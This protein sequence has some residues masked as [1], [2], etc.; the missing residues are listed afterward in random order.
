[1]LGNQEAHDVIRLSKKAQT[2]ENKWLIKSDQMFKKTADYIA[3]LVEIGIELDPNRIDFE[4]FYVDQSFDVMFEAFKTAQRMPQIPDKSRLAYPKGAMPRS[5]GELM[6]LWD[7]WRTKKVIPAR[8]KAIAAKVKKKYI[9]KVQKVTSK[10]NQ[11]ILNGEVVEKKEIIDDLMEVSKAD[12]ARS[13]TIVAT[14]TTRYWNK[15]RKD[16]YDQSPDV[17]HYLYLAVRD[18]ATTKWCRTRTGLV[19][20]KGDPILLRE[21]PPIHW[22]CR[23]ELLPLTPLNPKHL[24]LINDMTLRRR[25]HSPEPL[26]QGWN[27][28]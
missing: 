18:H 19:Y 12:R 28:G 25:N 8:Q 7:K 20:A 24:K 21:M 2:L 6:S 23:S 4:Q 9:E 26:P 5:L 13:N 17:T 15:I 14:E 3:G 11:R 1:M 16:T 22:W 27:R 10:Y